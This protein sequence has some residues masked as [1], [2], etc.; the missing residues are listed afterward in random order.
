[1]A[2][3]PM[4]RKSRN[5]FLLGMVITLVF[6]GA[7]LG[8][9]IYQQNTISEKLNYAESGYAYVLSQD[10]KSGDIITAD[11]LMKVKIHPNMQSADNQS[12]MS[13]FLN[14]YIIDQNGNQ[15]HGDAE[16][17][18]Y[19][20]NSNGEQIKIFKNANGKYYAN[21]N[22]ANVEI[23]I[24]GLPQIAKIDIAAKT[25]LTSNMI[26]NS[27]NAINKD[28]RLQEYNMLKL[29]ATLEV[30]EYIDIRLT[31]PTG[32]DY[33]VV[34]KKEVK[35]C[36]LTTIWVEVSED[37]ITT[38][39]NAIIES[40]IMTGAELYAVRYVEP[41]LQT[42]AIPTYPVS[43]AVRSAQS[44]NPN[45]LE[46]ARKAYNDRVAANDPTKDRT[47]IEQE[48]SKYADDRADNVEEGVENSA[49]QALESRENY[50]NGL[51]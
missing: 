21:I 9:L 27:E 48:L 38:M 35:L 17:G 8:F 25:P 23:Q 33:I 15:I 3:N 10:V 41:G 24:S 18:L 6:A 46:E 20:L 28:V 7:G 11:M 1:M 44:S 39:N 36:D 34:S 30:G 42:A 19:Y 12:I 22:G 47:Y 29:P 13:K 49:N 40:Y 37:E 45:I 43:Q 5:S 50:L 26:A 4:Q 16:S 2:L 32:Q 51:L 14:D 31:L